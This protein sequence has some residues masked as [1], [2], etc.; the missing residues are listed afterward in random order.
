MKYMIFQ[1]YLLLMLSVTTLPSCQ[2]VESGGKASVHIQMPSQQEVLQSQQKTYVD[3]LLSYKE[4]VMALSSSSSMTPSGFF[5]ETPIN[6]YM[7]MATGPETELQRNSCKRDADPAASA[8]RV[9]SWTGGISPGSEADLEVTSGKSR[10]IIVVGFHA[11]NGACKD[12]RKNGF[13]QNNL[14]K[15]YLVG[16]SD[17]LTL[18]AG[19]T[20]QVEISLNFE[21][22]KWFDA[23]TG[24]DFNLTGPKY[25]NQPYFRF[26][27]VGK[28]DSKLD[29]DI[30]TTGVC[31]P[32][33][34]TLQQNGYP[35]NNIESTD[36]EIDASAV[37]SGSFFT[38][39]D[40][41]QNSLL[42]KNLFI[43]KQGASSSEQF[44]FKPLKVESDLVFSLSL[45]K[46][47]KEIIYGQQKWNFGN[48]KLTV[49]GPAKLAL[50]SCGT[51]TLKREF[52]E[53]GSY[54]PNEAATITLLSGQNFNVSTNSDCS[55]GSIGGVGAGEEST[56]IY[57]QLLNPVLFDFSTAITSINYQTISPNVSFFPIGK[58]TSSSALV[59]N[60]AT[61]FKW[62]VNYLGVDV[63]TLNPKDVLMSGDG[64]DGCVATI[65]NLEGFNRSVSISGCSGNGP[66][67]VKIAEGSAKDLLGNVA[68]P[69]YTDSAIKLD[70]LSPSVTIN[71][72]A[73]QEDPTVVPEV[74]FSVVFS[75]PI[76]P[77]TFTVDDITNAGNANVESWS[78]T[79]SDSLNWLLTAKVNTVGKVIPS[80]GASKV[81]DL[82]G[83]L[84]KASSG[85]DYSV[86]VNADVAS[87]FLLDTEGSL[88]MGAG[89]CSSEMTFVVKDK[90]N[91]LAFPAKELVISLQGADLQFFES[92]TC[93][94]SAIISTKIT[95][96]MSQ[97]TLYAKSSVAGLK[98]LTA[99]S[100]MGTLS[101]DF[102]I[103][104][105]APSKLAFTQQP[106]NGSVN[107]DLTQQPIVGVYD[108]FNNLLTAANQSVTLTLYTD[109]KCSV[110]S[111]GLNASSFTTIDG[112]A[113]FKG[114]Q[115][116]LESTSFYLKASSGQLASSCSTIF[117]VNSVFSSNALK[118]SAMNAPSDGVAE[119]Y[120]TA[121]P[122]KSVD[123]N[124]IKLGSGKVIEISSK[125]TGTKIAGA[126][127]C[128]KAAYN[129]KKAIDNGDGS[130]T[131]AV[132][133]T[134]AALYDFS[135]IVID[136]TRDVE[137]GALSGLSFDTS[138]FVVITA[139]TNIDNSSTYLGKN[140]Y[141]KSGTATF[142]NSTVD[143]SFGDVFISGGIVNHSKTTETEIAR[144]KIKVASLT[145]LGGSINVS[146]LGYP[147]GYTYGGSYTVPGTR[148]NFVA[149]TK[150]EGSSHGGLGT[151]G[152]DGTAVGST[153]GDYRDPQYP[154]GGAYAG[155]TVAGGGVIN[156][157]SSNICTIKSG[158]TLMANAGG[159]AAAGGS[160]KLSC[161][162]FNGTFG[163][164]SITA[165]GG[166]FN[167]SNSSG[168]GG[169]GR[170]A[171]I[172]S[173]DATSFKG[174]FE[175]NGVAADLSGFKSRVNAY[176]GVG[177]GG[178]AAGTIYL[179]HSG[180]RYG[181]LIIDNYGSIFFADNG[182]TDLVSLAND[183]AVTATATSTS[184]N[185][186]SI[187]SQTNILTAMAVGAT[188][189]TTTST[190]TTTTTTSNTITA[191]NSTNVVNVNNST[192]VNSTSSRTNLY[193][194]MM[195][196]PDLSFSNSTE[197]WLDDNILTVVSNTDSGMVLSDGTVIS[198]NSSTNFRSLD[199]F[200]HLD[201]G[202]NSRLSSKGDILILSGP[203]IA[204]DTW[205]PNSIATNGN[206]VF[207]SLIPV[208]LEFDSNYGGSPLN[209]TESA[210]VKFYSFKITLPNHLVS[211]TLDLNG[212]VF[213]APSVR[214]VQNLSIG[215]SATQVNIPQGISAKNLV[216]SSATVVTSNISL[217]EAM[218]MSSGTLKHP[219]TTATEI[220]RLNIFAKTFNMTGGS[221]NVSGLGFLGGHTYGGSFKASGLR[222][223]F[224]S[225]MSYEGGSHAGKG[226]I[227]SGSLVGNTYGDY[228]DPQ[229]PGSGSGLIVTNGQIVNSSA[230][231]GVINIS[232]S[233]SCNLSSGI[234]IKADGVGYGSA[235]GSIKFNCG[236]LLGNI[237]AD[238]ITADG[239]SANNTNNIGGGGG[240]RIALIT[241]GG[242]T[243]FAGNFV[244]STNV[245]ALNAFKTRVHALGG[246]GAVTNSKNA[247]GGAG[248]VFLKHGDLPNGDLIID[249]EYPI[250][251]T[252]NGFTELV[253]VSGITSSNGQTESVLPVSGIVN[254]ESYS[255]LYAGMR[256]RPNI[257]FTN[258]TPSDLSDDNVV[259]VASN[260][261]SS[262]SIKEGDVSSVAAESIYRTVD[263]LDHIDINNGT[264]LSSRGDIYVVKGSIIAS[265]AHYPDSIITMDGAQ[266]ISAVPMTLVFDS[267]YTGS[268]LNISENINLSLS[269]PSVTFSND[270]N[271]QNLTLKGATLKVPNINVSQSLVIANSTLKVNN[272]F[273]AKSFSITNSSI[274]ANKIIS[275]E[276]ITIVSTLMTIAESIKA[277]NINLASGAI[278]TPN[279]LANQVFNMTG[280]ELKP[281]ATTA[282]VI[283]RLNINVGTFTMS[284]GMIHANSLGFLAGYTY[285]GSP[286]KPA[287]RTD[288][289][290]GDTYEGASHGG[291]GSKGSGSLVGFTY[292][293]YRD[294]QLPGSGFISKATNFNGG[295]V[296][297]IISTNV[298]TVDSGA[299]ISANG[300]NFGTAGGSIKMLCG[301]FAG[302]I[303]KDGLTVNGGSAN[304][305]SKYGA[306]GGGRIA[307]IS[308]G[309]AT[310]FKD[311]F[312]YTGSAS[313][314]TNF[315]TRVRAL[316][317]AGLSTATTLYASGGAGTVYL[318]HSGL[319][320][321]DLLIDNGGN[322]L[323]TYSGT[324][325]F[326]ASSENTNTVYSSPD[327][328]TLQITQSSTPFMFNLFKGMMIHIY[329][330]S[331]GSAGDNPYSKD[332]LSALISSNGN[333]TLISS[334]A[335]FPTMANN[336]KYRFIYQLDHLEV[337]G[338]ASV[339]FKGADL[340]LEADA[341]KDSCDLHSKY[342]LK[343]ILGAFDVPA[344][345]KMI[346]NALAASSC[347]D[348]AITTKATTVIFKSYFFK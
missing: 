228:R 126:A 211:Q 330:S 294:P 1:F 58:I 331:L 281:P 299:K 119:I 240:G 24:P 224:G 39:A 169:G 214:V 217:V 285:G 124:F 187:L 131:V 62:T 25:N 14:S 151:L 327:A 22:E 161:T 125:T 104:S 300:V 166:Y 142:L 239:T 76:N 154:G 42:A 347:L 242:A 67:T 177:T 92:S 204:G 147:A 6:C 278:T 195:V 252:Y 199:V 28:Y 64:A 227:G 170:I 111:A 110:A 85:R 5:G 316:G 259:T 317:G 140:L 243:S 271:L 72:L 292:D 219:P 19:T 336:Y 345:N 254:K 229:Y 262:L 116:T 82:V 213:S 276:D 100:T 313:N 289:T 237:G 329:P 306:G 216:L 241:N 308:T 139:N 44:Y 107:V 301:G 13:D 197:D 221:I 84:N 105:R 319:S 175:Y 61:A 180:L 4:N 87:Q 51:F 261:L 34:A 258:S 315:K 103:N 81:S 157:T 70:N 35:Y 196:R 38:E 176:G 323:T 321:G 10:S 127:D 29:K 200:D 247:A 348:K 339:D 284:A 77:A 167:T 155:A 93:S 60:K 91:K 78:I 269:S 16:K 305:T 173:G 171:L 56:S 279:L 189:T 191:T 54:T 215:G 322:N 30:A 304:S 11:Q 298:C 267:S 149:G 293:D 334:A 255:N 79:S 163:P 69:L 83:N 20:T 209:L 158:A 310:S 270:L 256:I 324:T 47:E 234:K 318:K 231:G 280:G 75:E 179:K 136:G 223:N 150:I 106:S 274:E 193:K 338:K 113:T 290:L 68:P 101:V 31:Y 133:A 181:D 99:S 17:S 115:L 112:Y 46:T 134:T 43:I 152:K 207:N 174:N 287:K 178:G 66:L 286:I 41:N 248:T 146:G 96:S 328:T 143:Q 206:G 128:R 162:G 260:N 65:S 156:I 230:G 283:N 55:A 26:E 342:L 185:T 251:S 130:Y 37:T 186:T 123:G 253:S 311:N 53:G 314:L 33:K 12:F 153:Y 246:N 235:G 245:T 203:I 172:S 264:R 340:M 165:N 250:L 9:G 272:I 220:N 335:N 225:G 266:F 288:L 303:G 238:A 346:G 341:T 63:V 141:I 21:S 307:L 23:C 160:I 320:Y 210:T 48:P 74:K 73:T 94:G 205:T 198:R 132:T 275:D 208:T 121:T 80:I 257:T 45:S 296:I 182:Y 212:I 282:D 71:Q 7:L 291:K 192:P 201:L 52:N 218:N 122:E 118:T 268:E 98:K 202:A 333:N 59:G 337:S 135:A 3:Q 326:L 40:C 145:M 222:E 184:L 188:N 137:V 226:A 88:T 95:T 32:V 148:A 120:L 90:Y 244:Y 138:K 50:K 332:R 302:R 297:N 108:Q 36:L 97:K 27:G 18:V 249:N 344:T 168:A 190:T 312:I 86:M 129:C 325:E 2:R 236:S 309:D 233:Q 144:L 263:I 343:P 109:A 277:N 232:V 15:P 194:G 49:S 265:E 273:S 57:I 117:S 114:V 164:K 183:S 159:F 102:K 8:M 89:E 295:G